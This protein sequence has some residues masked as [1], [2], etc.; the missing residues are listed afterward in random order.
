MQSVDEFT[1]STTE[2]VFGSGLISQTKTPSS[3]NNDVTDH[4][5][6]ISSSEPVVNGEDDTTVNKNNIK[7]KYY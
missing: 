7:W 3:T 4:E 2:P 6:S 1:P 5:K